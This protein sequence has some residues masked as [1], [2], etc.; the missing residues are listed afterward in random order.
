VPDPDPRADWWV[1]DDVAAYLGVSASTVASYKSRGQMPEP[2]RHFGRTPVWRP[3]TIIDWHDNRP[4]HGGRRPNRPP[5]RM[6][7]G[8]AADSD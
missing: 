6:G 1:P 8:Q 4:G 2:E 5:S 3:Q 7:G